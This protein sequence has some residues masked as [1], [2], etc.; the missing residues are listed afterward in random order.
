MQI[1]IYLFAARE[2]LDKPIVVG[3]KPKPTR[4]R[5]EPESGDS[6]GNRVRYGAN[7][8]IVNGGQNRTVGNGRLIAFNQWNKKNQRPR[9]PCANPPAKELFPRYDDHLEESLA[10]ESKAFFYE[11]LKNDLSLENF[12]DSDFVMINERLARRFSGKCWCT[13]FRRPGYKHAG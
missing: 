11:I 3:A 4:W 6:D 1:E 8:A 2:I 5:F 9:F 13:A 10:R 12:I 7:N